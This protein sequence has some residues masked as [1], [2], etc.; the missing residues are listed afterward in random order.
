MTDH[1]R[2]IALTVDEQDPG[3][4]FW[5]LVESTEDATV[6]GELEASEESYPSWTLALRAGVAALERLAADLQSG[7]RAQGEDENA[8]PVKEARSISA[9]PD[10]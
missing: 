5:V 10:D 7:P 8:A 4:F 2:N 3:V 9:L 1:L 6:F